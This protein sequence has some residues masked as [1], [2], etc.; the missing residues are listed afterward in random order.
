MSLD[1]AAGF[2]Y[3]LLGIICISSTQGTAEQESVFRCRT[4][5]VSHLNGFGSVCIQFITSCTDPLR[6]ST[7]CLG[8]LRH[9]TPMHVQHPEQRVL[10]YGRSIED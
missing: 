7:V 9:V 6:R 1:H 10:Y 5:P 8:F 3:K 2:L 4:R